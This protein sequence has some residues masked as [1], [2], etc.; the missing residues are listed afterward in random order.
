[1]TA[2][3]GFWAVVG[4]SAIILLRINRGGSFNRKMGL[5]RIKERKK[6]GEGLRYKMNYS[7]EFPLLFFYFLRRYFS[8]FV[9]EENCHFLECKKNYIPHL[10]I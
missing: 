4:G 9:D 1:M 6:E 3:D 7:L 8:A 2:T 10:V 5:K